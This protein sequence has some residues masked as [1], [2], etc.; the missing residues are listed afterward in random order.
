MQPCVLAGLQWLA[1]TRN[2]AH[3]LRQNTFCNEDEEKSTEQKVTHR[4][5][6]LYDIPTTE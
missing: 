5:G 4:T 2:K 6:S 3:L 1:L